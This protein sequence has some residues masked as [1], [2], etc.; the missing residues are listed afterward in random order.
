[1]ASVKARPTTSPRMVYARR[2]R[3]LI[4]MYCMEPDVFDMSPWPSMLTAVLRGDVVEGY[5]WQFGLGAGRW[6]IEGDTATRL[7]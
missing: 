4:G 3:D 7:C 1:M 6:R 2:L 5:G